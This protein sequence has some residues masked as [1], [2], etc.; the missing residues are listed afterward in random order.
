MNIL[1]TKQLI[2]QYALAEVF[3]YT[4]EYYFLDTLTKSSKIHLAIAFNNTSRYINDVIS[5]NNKH[6][7]IYINDIYLSE[8]ELK[9]TMKSANNASYLD[10]LAYITVYLTFKFYDKRDNF[11]FPIDNFPHLDKLAYGVS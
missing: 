6:F 7:G 10:I 8:F 11:N 1:T 3:L 2:F 5:L 4:Y 9:E